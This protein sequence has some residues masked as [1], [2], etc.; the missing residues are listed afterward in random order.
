MAQAAGNLFQGGIT[1][2]TVAAPANRT[3]AVDHQQVSIVG[4]IESSGLLQLLLAVVDQQESVVLVFWDAVFDAV[5]Y[6]SADEPGYVFQHRDRPCR[7]AIA[8][9][10]APGL[11]LRLGPMS[12]PDDEQ[13]R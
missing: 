2:G 8:N 1:H 7:K 4:P 12:E 3:S 10:E 11:G 6:H 5:R 13:R 9:A